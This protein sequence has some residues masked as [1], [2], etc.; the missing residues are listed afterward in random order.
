MKPVA[1]LKL[2]REVRRTDSAAA[3]AERPHRGLKD[4]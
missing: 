2:E 1:K 4:R 3:E